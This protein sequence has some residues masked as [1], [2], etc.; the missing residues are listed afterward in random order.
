[1]KRDPKLNPE[2]SASSVR[3]VCG[4]HFDLIYYNRYPIVIYP[5][6][7]LESCEIPVF[8]THL[9]TF[10]FKIPGDENG[11]LSMLELFCLQDGWSYEM[12]QD[13][14]EICLKMRRARIL[15]LNELASYDPVDHE[16]SEI[17]NVKLAASVP[18][19]AMF[20]RSVLIWQYLRVMP[21]L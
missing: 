11:S 13:F 5:I 7:H 18:S 17:P 4:D 14:L 8:S 12:H 21:L 20:L 9:P 16:F 19:G 3:H 6:L 15:G 2:L 10:L 1:M